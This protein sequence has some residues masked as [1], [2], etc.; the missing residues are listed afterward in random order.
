VIQTRLPASRCLGLRLTNGDKVFEQDSA[1]YFPVGLQT[2][3]TAMVDPK[4]VLDARDPGEGLP[5]KANC[6]SNESGVA[7]VGKNLIGS[8]PYG[9]D[10]TVAASGRSVRFMNDQGF[11]GRRIARLLV[12]RGNVDEILKAKV[13][14]LKELKN[15]NDSLFSTTQPTAKG[16]QIRSAILTE[17]ELQSL[18]LGI[19]D[20][21]WP[22]V[23]DGA[24][25]GT[26][27]FYISVDRFGQVREALPL[28][29]ANE[30]SNDSAQRQIMKWK[31]KPLMKDGASVQAEST[32]TF[33]LDT[34]AWGPVSPLSD[35]EMRKLAT[36]IVEPEIPPGSAPAGTT[37]TLRAAID[38]D[39]KLIE[40]IAGDGPPNLFQPCYQALL[41]WHFSPILQ[42]GEPRPYRAEVKFQV[43]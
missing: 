26:T 31:F 18:A 10:E 11:N 4:S 13:T 25:T 20:I 1:N 8:G 37:Y 28:C 16:E 14:E 3:V 24:T 7:A 22:Q 35:A 30:R 41:K 40:V 39:G 33:T 5:T 34:R 29:T 38:S 6:G 19:H 32:L 43:Q 2:L 15:P 23:L 42:N 27:K 17:A 21:I 12:H 36:N 9:L